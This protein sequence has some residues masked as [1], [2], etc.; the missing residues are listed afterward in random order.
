M[1][2]LLLSLT[3]GAADV[4]AAEPAPVT[5]WSTKHPL[6][7]GVRGGF[8][9]GEYRSG[10]FGGHLDLR[11]HQRFGLQTYADVF[12]SLTPELHRR[13]HVI[14]FDLYAPLGRAEKHWFAPTF[15]TCVDFRV[16]DQP[17]GG[18]SAR[19][20][21]FGVHAGAKGR[22]GIYRG[23]AVE[24][25]GTFTTYIGKGVDLEGWTS[26]TSSR[27]Q[28]EPVGQLTTAITYMF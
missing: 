16:F 11:L 12:L 27:L 4:D 3:A 10:G 24:I 18:P 22:F 13:D 7:A 21:R 14:G 8:W 26:S 17:K 6:S 2:A 15:G 1:I 20:V 28:V 23:L 5:A 25:I 9:A 19:D